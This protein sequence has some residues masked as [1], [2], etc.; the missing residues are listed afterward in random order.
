MDVRAKWPRQP[1]FGETRERIWSERRSAYLTTAPGAPESLEARSAASGDSVNGALPTPLLDAQLLIDARVANTGAGDD[2]PKSDANT[3]G[4]ASFPLPRIAA[5]GRISDQ[6][7]IVVIGVFD[8]ALEPVLN[9]GD[10][11]IHGHRKPDRGDDARGL[12]DHDCRYAGMEALSSARRRQN[13][14]F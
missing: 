9:M 3:A 10:F 7:E 5:E 1:A 4:G 2:P 14:G 6:S 8:K 12:L 13:P 11:G